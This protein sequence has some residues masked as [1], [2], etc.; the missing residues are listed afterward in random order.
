[1]RAFDL[2]EMSFLRHTW[3]LGIE[4]QFYTLW[5]LGLLLLLRARNGRLTSIAVVC[6]GIAPARRCCGRSGG[7]GGKPC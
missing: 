1:V 4:E 5:P 2:T 7:K 6:A 3:S